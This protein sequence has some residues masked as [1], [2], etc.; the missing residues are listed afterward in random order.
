MRLVWIGLALVLLSLPATA[1]IEKNALVCKSSICFY[2][3]PKLPEPKGWH[4]DRDVSYRMNANVLVP[5]GSTFANAKTVI[6]AEAIYKPREPTVTSVEVLIAND[7]EQFL[8][9]RPGIL[10]SESGRL[11]TGDGQLLRSFTFF[12]GK[13]GDWEKVS[14]GEEGDFYLI[15]TVSSRTEQAYRQDE[16]VY[17]KLVAGYK[18][19][20]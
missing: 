3:W 12:P 8:Q 11:N 1:E 16:P 18:V 9:H 4:Q 20:P 15:F 7:K 19:K 2:W 17:G 5:D 13:Q 6:Y 10:I 14:Y